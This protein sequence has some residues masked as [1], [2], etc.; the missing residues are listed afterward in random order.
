MEINTLLRGQ[1]LEAIPSLN[2]EQNMEPTPYASSN[3]G[4][5]PIGVREKAYLEEREYPF[6]LKPASNLRIFLRLCARAQKTYK[7]NAP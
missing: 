3:P 4:S 7:E 1:I 5:D 2:G 6:P